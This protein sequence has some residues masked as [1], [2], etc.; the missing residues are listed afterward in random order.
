MRGPFR[1]VITDTASSD[2]DEI[3]AQIAPASLQNAASVLEGLIDAI[4]SL[5]FLPYRYNVYRR[6]K[7]DQGPVR[8]MPVPPFVI[9]YQVIENDGVVLIMKV[10]HGRRRRPRSFG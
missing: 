1:V 5:K 7:K 8:S 4:F 10:L 6:A 9:Y 2:L 3:Y